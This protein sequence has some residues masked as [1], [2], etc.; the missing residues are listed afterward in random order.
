MAQALSEEEFHRM[1]VQISLFALG[2]DIRYNLSARMIKVISG[3]NMCKCVY[4]I[5]EADVHLGRLGLC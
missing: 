5:A 3:E 1:Q 2:F 4:F